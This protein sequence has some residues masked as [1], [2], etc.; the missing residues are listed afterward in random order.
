MNLQQLIKI[1]FNPRNKHRLLALGYATAV[2]FAFIL[3][4]TNNNSVNASV[5]RTDKF[6]YI[7]ME[8]SIQDGVAGAET[9]YPES[10]VENIKSLYEMVNYGNREKTV[11]SEIEISKGDTLI[12]ILSD[13]GLE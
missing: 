9:I 13:L 8:N 1:D 5:S 6:D 12:S 11:E 2:T 7:M 10:S 4:L 3:S